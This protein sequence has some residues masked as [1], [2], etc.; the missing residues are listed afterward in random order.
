MKH[1]RECPK[2]GTIGSWNWAS[3]RKRKL[4][5]NGEYALIKVIKDLEKAVKCP[6]CNH[7]FEPRSHEG[8]KE[9]WKEVMRELSK[10]EL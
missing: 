2:C 9:A 5:P 8:F 4:L 3:K 7:T 1:N 6:K 10:M